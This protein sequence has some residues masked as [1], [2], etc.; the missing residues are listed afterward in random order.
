MTSVGDHVSNVEKEE[1][2]EKVWFG[3]LQHYYKVPTLPP[4]M[5]QQRTFTMEAMSNWCRTLY[6][7]RVMD[8]I[9]LPRECSRV[10]ILGSILCVLEKQ[11]PNYHSDFFAVA[12]HL[13]VHVLKKV[14]LDHKVQHYHVE[15]GVDACAYI[16][17][18]LP[19][20]MSYFG[21]FCQ[22]HAP[23]DQSKPVFFPP[24]P[25]DAEFLSHLDQRGWMPSLPES[26]GGS[27]NPLKKILKDFS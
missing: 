19:V 11:R 16:E 3:R 26:Y 4:N 18:L 20:Q 15:K 2:D 22:L 12:E 23:A 14:P 21:I 6:P 8:G 13:A 1:E 17:M 10:K 7:V 24:M 5:K 27:H 25:E 9:A